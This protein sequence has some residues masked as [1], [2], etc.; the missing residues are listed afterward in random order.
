M[1]AFR[2]L[3]HSQ[4]PEVKSHPRVPF[5][6][7]F[8]AFASSIPSALFSEEGVTSALSKRSGKRK[9]SAPPGVASQLS[10]KVGDALATDRHRGPDPAAHSVGNAEVRP[11]PG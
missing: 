3:S 9:R 2:L 1:P 6:S 4:S 11:G 10:R 8:R 5:A 7:F